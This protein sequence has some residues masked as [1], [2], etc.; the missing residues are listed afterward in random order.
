M[1]LNIRNYISA[2]P[3]ICHGKPCFKGTRIPVSLIL[4]MI[5]GGDSIESILEGYPTLSREAIQAALHLAGELIDQKDIRSSLAL[6][7]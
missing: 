6:H 7:R 5:E 2:S 1:E 3:A 4:H